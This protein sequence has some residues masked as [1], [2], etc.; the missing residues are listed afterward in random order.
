MRILQVVIVAQAVQVGWHHCDIFRGVMDVVGAGYFGSSDL[1]QRISPVG[2]LERPGQQ[3]FFLDRLQTR[4]GI[5]A[6]RT[7]KEQAAHARTIRFVNDIDGNGQ[8][9]RNELGGPGG[10]GQNPP[11][12]GGSQEDIRRAYLPQEALNPTPP[13]E[14]PATA[15]ARTHA[16]LP[17]RA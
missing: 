6:T 9:L 1:S 14:V 11:Y 10:V 7:E 2:A 4:L 5:N 8:V 13:P 3:V 12:L 17:P 15:T 16:P